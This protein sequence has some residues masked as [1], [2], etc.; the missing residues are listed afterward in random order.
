MRWRG[1]ERTLSD[2]LI[3]GSGAGL[4]FWAVALPFD[5]LKS[6][7]QTKLP[8]PSKLASSGHWMRQSRE[9]VQQRGIPSLFRGATVAFGRGAPSAAIT[10]T[11][12]YHVKEMIVS[13]SAVGESA[14]VDEGEVVFF[15]VLY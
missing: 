15:A 4:A 6:V 14:R 12:Y 13:D 9:F 10:I 3:A 5:T 7:V 11:T 1:G 2:K 8:D